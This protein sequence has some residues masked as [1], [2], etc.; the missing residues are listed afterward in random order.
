MNE[1]AKHARRTQLPESVKFA[2]NDLLEAK[3]S[4]LEAVPPKV[5]LY[6]G[7]P[8]SCGRILATGKSNYAE[9]LYSEEF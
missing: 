4:T 3:L 9:L 8:V 2:E 5:S 1:N 6:G 7:Q